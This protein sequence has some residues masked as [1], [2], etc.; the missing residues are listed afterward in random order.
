MNKLY[1]KTLSI[2]ITRRCNMVCAHCMRGDPENLDINHQHIRSLLKHVTHVHRLTITGGEPSLNPKAIRYILKQLK[3]FN[4]HVY[5]FY[6][7]TNGSI[8]SMSDQFISVCSDLFD[9]QENKDLEEH[10]HMLELSDDRF[11][12]KTLHEKVTAKLRL[13]PFFGTRGQSQNI[14]LFK[15][16]RCTTGEQN[17]VHHIYLTSEN[18]VYGDIYLN[19]KGNILGNGN[20]SYQRQLE[21]ELCHVNK[22]REYLKTTLRKD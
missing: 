21:N 10:S 12:D 22:L 8:S 2:E 16:G 17:K 19:A 9:Y 1:I 18:Y 3:S 7:V 13:Y 4:I 6:I 20:L 11:H 5:D 15:E 14:Y